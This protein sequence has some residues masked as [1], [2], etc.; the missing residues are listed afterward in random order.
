VWQSV[1][2][3][4]VCAWGSPSHSAT[5]ASSPV[6]SLHPTGVSRARSLS[7]SERE[8]VCVREIER[9]C[10]CVC[11]RES[12]CERESLSVTGCAFVCGVC[13]GVPFA[14]RN[15]GGIPGLPCPP[16]THAVT[17]GFSAHFRPKVGYLIPPYVP[18][19]LPTEGSRAN[20]LPGYSRNPFVL[21]CA[22]GSASWACPSHSTTR[23]S[24]PVSPLPSL[25]RCRA[26]LAPI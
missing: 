17:K 21:R 11:V 24:S 4:V 22:S 19:A 2:L 20:P 3:C 25:V 13:L 26:S 8:R 23:A 1:R 18:T 10:L 9:E 12:V 15:S 16:Y 5:L 7:L 14:F 6:T